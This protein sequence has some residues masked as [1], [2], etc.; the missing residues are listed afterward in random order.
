[1]AVGMTLLPKA[2]LFEFGLTFVTSRLS[3]PIHVYVTDM[4]AQNSA[5]YHMFTSRAQETGPCANKCHG[6][7]KDMSTIA[8]DTSPVSSMAGMV[9]VL[10]SADLALTVLGLEAGIIEEGN[11][12]M[13]HLLEVSPVVFIVAKAVLTAF[14]AVV[15]CKWG[16]SLL[17]VRAMVR[18]VLAAYL[19]VMLLHAEWVASVAIAMG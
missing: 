9:V 18:L 2:R 11:P 14:F 15:V 6:E 17:W 13:E 7:V 12:F 5:F 3:V 16:Q 10:S 1:M 8:R 19:G 4:V